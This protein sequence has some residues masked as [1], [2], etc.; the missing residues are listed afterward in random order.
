MNIH[1]LGAV[2][3]YLQKIHA[4]GDL[5]NEASLAAQIAKKRGMLKQ[6]K[7]NYE[8]EKNEVINVLKELNDLQKRMN[9]IKK[10]DEEH[11]CETFDVIDFTRGMK[12]EV[13]SQ[14]TTVKLREIFP[15]EITITMQITFTEYL[16]FFSC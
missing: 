14:S 15:G 12:R 7:I 5:S 2:P 1:K 8:R 13:S 9:K 3:K 16:I 10:L 11:D 6:K 4:G